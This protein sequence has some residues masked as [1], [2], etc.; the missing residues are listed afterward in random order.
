MRRIEVTPGFP[1]F[2]LL[3]HVWGGSAFWPVLAAM[4][5]HELAHAAA[6]L[7]LGGTLEGLRLGFAQLTLR[8][9]ILPLP[10]E[11]I[12]TAAGPGVNL[13]CGCLLGQAA[14]VFAAASLLLGI[15]NLLPVW[16]LDGG[17]LLRTALTAAFGTRGEAAAD[18]GS[19]IF[20][21]AL[22]LA[23]AALALRRRAGLWPLA[24]VGLTLLRLALMRREEKA[25]AFPRGKG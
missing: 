13:L 10:A 9:G 16:P 1:A 24:A 2:L 18:I 15:F 20:S 22:L 25:V 11:L 7:L 17:R 14:P 3:L 5:V 8:T 4:S 19:G 23:A 6:L 12:G 21:A